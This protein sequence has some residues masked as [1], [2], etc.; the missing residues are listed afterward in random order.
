MCTRCEPEKS[1]DLNDLGFIERPI[2][3]RCSNSMQLPELYERL[4]VM[5]EWV[6][7]GRA[8]GACGWALQKRI[9]MLE[10]ITFVQGLKIGLNLH[11][12]DVAFLHGVGVRW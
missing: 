1:A 3:Y 4:P 12:N 6:M 9:E 2:P 7:T 11:E 5:T 8:C 10:D